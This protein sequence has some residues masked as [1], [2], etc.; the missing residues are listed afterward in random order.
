MSKADQWGLATS[1]PH[2][3][4]AYCPKCR[5]TSASVGV[6]FIDLR[7]REDGL[8]RCD[9]CGVLSRPVMEWIGP[10]QTAFLYPRERF[11]GGPA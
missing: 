5:A 4:L 10:G 7:N 1:E 2:D 3:G 6:R 9:G 11:P 8:A